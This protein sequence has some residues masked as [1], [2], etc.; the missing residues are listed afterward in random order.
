MRAASVVWI[1]FA[2]LSVSA[3]QAK[4][5]TWCANYGD[6]NGGRN[7]GFHSYQQCQAAVSG[8]GGFCTRG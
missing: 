6:A 7:C 8:T 5:E 3:T 1:I 2:L 4:A